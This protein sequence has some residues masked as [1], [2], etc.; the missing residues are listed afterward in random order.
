MEPNLYCALG[1]SYEFP[2]NFG[3]TKPLQQNLGPSFTPRSAILLLLF[4]NF[5]GISRHLKAHLSYSVSAHSLPQRTTGYWLF[6]HFPSTLKLV[7]LL[8]TSAVDT[9]QFFGLFGVSKP[10][11]SGLENLSAAASFLL[12]YPGS[13]SSVRLNQV[14]GKLCYFVESYAALF[15]K[16]H[17]K[18]RGELNKILRHSF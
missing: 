5:C 12:P 3:Q 11:S 6:G 8:L 14:V 13:A 4:F 10:F 9:S 2:A 15:I 17:R 7:L 1:L 16:S 18:I